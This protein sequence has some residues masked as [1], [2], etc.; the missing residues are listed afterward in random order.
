MALCENCKRSESGVVRCTFNSR[1]QH[2]SFRDKPSQVQG[3]GSKVW[4][5]NGKL[6][7]ENGPA[8]ECASGRNYYYYN[9]HEYSQRDWKILM[10]KKKKFIT[11]EASD[12]KFQAGLF[13]LI[14]GIV[15]AIILK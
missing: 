10:E 12:K 2:H 13:V 15:L 3:D 7:R 1:R 6:H 8:Y 14:V 11:F 5:R 4:H 9:D